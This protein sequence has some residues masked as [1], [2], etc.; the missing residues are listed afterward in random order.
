M[1]FYFRYNVLL[2]NLLRV[3]SDINSVVSFIC[4]MKITRS[5]E[6]LEENL[7]GS[8]ELPARDGSAVEE[9]KPDYPVNCDDE[10]Y[11]VEDVY[12]SVVGHRPMRGYAY[13]NEKG[14]YKK[15]KTDKGEVYLPG[16]EYTHF[17]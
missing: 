9:C 1:L 17:N 16:G 11:L 3:I 2:I 7:T 12:V 15:F 14:V 13:L 4:D 6:D 5:T 8:K 10:G